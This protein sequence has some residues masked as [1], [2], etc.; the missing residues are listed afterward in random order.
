MDFS[1]ITGVS[2][3]VLWRTGIIGFWHKYVTP[4]YDK[5]RPEVTTSPKV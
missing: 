4:K 2:G 3:Y 5:H 1:L